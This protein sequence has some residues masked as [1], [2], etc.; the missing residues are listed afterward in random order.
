MTD[1]DHTHEFEPEQL[2]DLNTVAIAT[3][4][5]Q[6]AVLPRALDEGIY[7]VLDAEGA[8]QIVET[9]GYA[10]ERK[11]AWN[12]AHSD[13]PEF[14]HRQV[15]LLNVD[16]FIDYLAHNT[17][18]MNE[19]FDE[20][21]DPEYSHGAGELEM[22]AD[23]D[24]RTIKAVLD[25]FDGLRKHAATL[26]LK[27]SREW[28]EWAAID[29]KI[30]DQVTFAQFIEDHLSTIAQPDGAQLLDIC[31]T[32]EATKSAVFKQQTILAS[33]QRGFRHEEQVEGKAGIKGDLT[34]PGE[35]T[36][37][38]RPFQGSDPIPIT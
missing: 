21:L 18:T 36:L 15:T 5:A 19:D 2:E 7:A 10:Q 32:L 6:Q 13:T 25:G 8:V 28:S 4:N 20:V 33:G 12:Q 9:K 29:G 1:I 37:V 16:S 23:L 38:L 26:Q 22:W 31:Q 30:L 34:I 35:L 3:M 27:L 14:V 17:R 24:A 11:H